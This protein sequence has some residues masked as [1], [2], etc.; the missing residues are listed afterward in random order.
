MLSRAV[1]SQ[2]A[3]RA[4]YNLNANEPLLPRHLAGSFS[5]TRLRVFQRYFRIPTDMQGYTGRGNLAMHIRAERMSKHASGGCFLQG[6][7]KQEE[8]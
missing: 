3:A 4:A 6:F 2:V 1:L 7:H 8:K 5:L